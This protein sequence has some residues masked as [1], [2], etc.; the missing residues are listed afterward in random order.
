[1][2]DDLRSATRMIFQMLESGD[3]SR[4]EEFIDRGVVDHQ[5][6]PGIEGDGIER[7]RQ[8]TQMFHKAFSDLRFNLEDVLVDGDNVVARGTVSGRHTGEFMGMP[9]TG[10][11]FSIDSIDIM[12]FQNG[13]AVE[14][15]GLTDD[16]SMA[17]QL[18]MMPGQ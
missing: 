18:G 5:E 16:M 9:A 8:F 14:H 10:K 4:A 13:R 2:P 3:L 1:M 12:R 15:W 7:L 11:S 6:M 17:R